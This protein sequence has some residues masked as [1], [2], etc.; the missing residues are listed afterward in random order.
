[1]KLALKAREVYSVVAALEHTVFNSSLDS[2]ICGFLFTSNTVCQLG[3]LGVLFLKCGAPVA[4]PAELGLCARL[5]LWK[6]FK[7]ETTAL[8][9][10]LLW[11]SG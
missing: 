11:D 1:M 3:T 8:I 9:L 6:C 4:H 2:C 10:C 5:Q 7:R